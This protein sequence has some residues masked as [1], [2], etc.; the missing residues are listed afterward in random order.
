MEIKEKIA[1]EIFE[2][3]FTGF[4]P[5]WAECA[6]KS[7]WLNLANKIIELFEQAGY[8]QLQA[9][10]KGLAELTNPC[11]G[12]IHKSKIDCEYCDEAKEYAIRM[13][14]IKK[15]KALCDKEKEELEQTLSYVS[16]VYCELT[17]GKFSK[18]NT[19]KVYILGAVE[20]SYKEIIKQE[21]E[22]AVEKCK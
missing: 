6:N 14:Y 18:P 21:K 20:E 17:N 8:I 9:D 19:D 13:A 3:D 15:Q 10:D 7:H 16:E 11:A 12:C 5:K 4:N 22:E 2:Y 1:R